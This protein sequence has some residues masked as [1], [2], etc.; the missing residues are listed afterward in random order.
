MHMRGMGVKAEV[1]G[2]V[3]TVGSKRLMESESIDL[4]TVRESE[5]E[6]LRKGESVAFVAVDG[7]MAGLITYSDKLREESCD[8]I[9]QL[10]R[11]GVKKLIMAT[12][13]SESAASSIAAACGIDEV[14]ARAFPEQ[15]ADLVKRLKEAG[16]RVAVIGDGINDSPALA[17]ADVA[18]SLHGGTEAARH[19]A[20]IVL[21]DADLRRLP[22][23]IKIARSSM[24]LVRQNLSLAVIPNTAGLGLAAFGMVGPAGATLLNNGS[25]ICAALNSL[26]PLFIPSWSVE[27]DG[28]AVLQIAA[29]TSVETEG[30]NF[31]AAP[32]SV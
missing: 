19:S 31:D 8:A 3:V 6:A 22:E 7:E 18:I 4:R 12:G 1:N 2:F 20:D 23:A 29:E 26:R 32:P 10:K 5:T 27:K 15:K 25:A 9:K 17:H 11:L 16:Y 30:T 21:T 24:N 28:Q 13:D 14:I